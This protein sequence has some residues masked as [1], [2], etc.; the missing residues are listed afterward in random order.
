MRR[1]AIRRVAVLA[2]AIVAAA[3]LAGCGDDGAGGLFETTCDDIGQKPSNLGDST[4]EEVIVLID[5]SANDEAT[6]KRIADDAGAVLSA[7]LLNSDHLV[8]TGYVAGGSTASMEKIEC[9]AGRE[10]VFLGGN[11]RRQAAERE[12][13]AGQLE[14]EIAA[15]VRATTIEAS[16][17]ARVLLRQVPTIATRPAPL[18]ILWSTFLGQG[19]DCLTFETGDSPSAQLA[20]A[21]AER[22]TDQGL[23]P[24]LGDARLTVVGAGSSAD[25]PDLGPFGKQLAAALCGRMAGE[26][27]VR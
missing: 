24:D 26:C 9:M 4:P 11:E 13:L 10:Y 25:R 6:A 12:D 27:D 23:L 21:V 18:V 2:V 7:V 16:G 17:D 8:L 5:A 15:A 20:E 1:T 3:S 22:C 19:S 14:D